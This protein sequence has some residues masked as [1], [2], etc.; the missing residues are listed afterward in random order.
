MISNNLDVYIYQLIYYCIQ[1]ETLHTNV[2]IHEDVAG[3]ILQVHILFPCT[4][5]VILTQVENKTTISTKFC[6]FI[7]T[8]R[9]RIIN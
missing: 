8:S 5:S 4:H 2:A 3:Y 1:F 6:L 7:Y 9:T